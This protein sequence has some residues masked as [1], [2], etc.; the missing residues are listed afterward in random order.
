[1]INATIGILTLNSSKT[2]FRCL[3]NLTSFDEI[4]ILDGGSIDSTLEIAKKFNCRIISQ[5]KN[6]KFPNKRIKNFSQARNLI[7]ERAKHDLILMIDSDEVLHKNQLNKIDFLSKS[8]IM[9]KR[10]YCFLMPRVPVLK[11]SEY[12]VTSLFPNFQPRLIYKS[13]V[14][15]YIKDVHEKP[16]PINHKLKQLKLKDNYINFSV[17]LTDIQIKKKLE[18]YFLIEKKMV[19]N[20]FFKTLYYIFNGLFILHKMFAKILLYKKSNKNII[21]YEKKM[22]L[23]RIFYLYL[24]LINKFNI[25]KIFN[26]DE[27]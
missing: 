15:K 5:K 7:L 14:K 22:I 12:K 23:S 25:F 16:I 6:F 27:L 2:I 26:K 4:I 11:N 20:N 1:M 9:K 8:K 19:S 10:Y 17:D 18:Y 13:N 21:V 24:L 3:N